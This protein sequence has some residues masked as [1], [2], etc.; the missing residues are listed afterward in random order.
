MRKRIFK[1]TESQYRNYLKEA[2]GDNNANNDVVVSLKN[3]SEQDKNPTNISTTLEKTRKYARN[4]GINTNNI[5]TEVEVEVNGKTEELT[6]KPQNESRVF[7][8]NQLKRSVNEN[9]K[10][11]I[12]RIS[13]LVNCRYRN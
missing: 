4:S 10:N 13:D 2:D 1:I 9:K 8:I 6:S 7:T 12:I 11:K 3:P 5:S